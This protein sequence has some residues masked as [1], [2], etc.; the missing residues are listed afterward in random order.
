MSLSTK[1]RTII[2]RVAI[3][4]LFLVAYFWCY[5]FVASYFAHSYEGHSTTLNLEARYYPLS[6]DGV[7]SVWFADGSLVAQGYNVSFF[8]KLHPQSLVTRKL[9]TE[10]SAFYL[11][12]TTWH[13]LHGFSALTGY[14]D[15]IFYN[16]STQ[17]SLIIRLPTGNDYPF[18]A[19]YT[20]H[21][22]SLI[23]LGGGNWK[24]G[25]K[26]NLGYVVCWRKHI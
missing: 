3:L 17:D 11:P 22:T 13:L 25:Y 16:S 19:A 1:S 8:F 21:D 14:S 5:P 12:D 18:F 2:T 7:D 4:V 26:T 20:S 6:L 9:P 23:V 10:L 15:C 24:R